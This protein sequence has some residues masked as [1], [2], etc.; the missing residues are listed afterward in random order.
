MG[1]LPPTL[2]HVGNWERLRDDSVTIS[3]RMAAAN[4]EATL[5]IFGGM[6]H[7]WQLFAPM[8]D[9]GMASIEESAAFIRTNVDAAED[10]A[11]SPVP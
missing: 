4:V 9:E 10:R 3:E 5:K 7:G 8:L 1:G 11:R 6:C 2:V